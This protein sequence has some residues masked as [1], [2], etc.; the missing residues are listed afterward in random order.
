VKTACRIRF[1]MKRTGNRLDFTCILKKSSRAHKKTPNLPSLAVFDYGYPFS[2][3]SCT[4]R[5]VNSE[6]QSLGLTEP[7]VYMVVAS[8]I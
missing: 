7:Y 1:W 3:F 8:H 4:L 2:V 5:R 6:R